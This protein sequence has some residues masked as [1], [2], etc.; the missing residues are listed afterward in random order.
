[1]CGS[2]CK[3]GFR[4]LII[5]INMG[6]QIMGFALFTRGFRRLPPT[7]SF[8]A[9]SPFTWW[10]SCKFTWDF[11]SLVHHDLVV[12]ALGPCSLAGSVLHGPEQDGRRPF[13]AE[14]WRVQCHD[15]PHFQKEVWCHL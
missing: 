8:N 7:W 5:F 15:V 9:V 6:G 1:L 14:A 4:W 12:N 11:G 10:N 3:T 13:P 2:S